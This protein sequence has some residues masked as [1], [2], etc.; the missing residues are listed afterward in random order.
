MNSSS[1]E[2]SRASKDAPNSKPNLWQKWKTS[3]RNKII[4]GIIAITPVVLTIYFI[5][6]VISFFDR[7]V[8]PVL[9]PL[10]GFHL[11]GLGLIVA[12]IA[13]YLLGLFITNFLGKSILLI[14][15]KW[16]NYIPIVRTIYNTS[17]QVMNALS[18]SKAGFEKTVMV[19][20]PRKNTWV[21]GFLT[22]EITNYDGKRFL[23][24]FLPTTPNPTSGWVI[25]YPE[26]E[27]YPSDMNI[28][29]GLKAII[30]AGAMMPPKLNLSSADK[31]NNS[32]ANKI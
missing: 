24:I 27:V 30:S 3:Q 26:D 1:P 10:I 31:I 16:L 2:N 15:E 4:A 9:D 18:F 21:I 17:K 6:L 20:Y 29:Q 22:G 13:I 12:F 14:V 8:S 28:E 11:P 25:F 32:E 23:S 19:E 5:K 7:I